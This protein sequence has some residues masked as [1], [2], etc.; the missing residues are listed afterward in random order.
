MPV[1]ID[2]CKIDEMNEIAQAFQA[3][4]FHNGGQPTIQPDS[5]KNFELITY[6]FKPRL[7]KK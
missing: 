7:A 1:T 5:F 4:V 2:E 3:A 6:A